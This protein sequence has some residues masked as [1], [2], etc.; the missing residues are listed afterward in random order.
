MKVSLFSY[1]LVALTL[2]A[3]A[4]TGSNAQGCMGGDSGAGVKVQG[5]IQ[6]QFNYFMN[7]TDADG[8]SLDVNN[9]T[10]NR[11]RIGV[12]G[13]I[14]YDIEY[15]FFIETSS[16]KTPGATP[17]MLDAYVSYTRFSKWAKLSLG[18][19]KSPF[20]LEQNTSCSGL[21]T[22]NRS[23]VVNQLAGPQRDLGVMISGGHDTMYVRYSVGL[24]NGTGINIV[25]NNNNK[26]IVGRVVIIPHEMFKV[27]GSFRASKI[28]PTDDT[29]KL[30]DMTV[31]GGEFQ[32]TWKDLI[33]QA[34]YIQG[35]NKLYSASKIPIYGG[36]GGIVGYNTLTE[37]TYTK[38]GMMFMAAYKT[39]W[40][41]EPVFK[42]DTWDPDH[43]V[44]TDMI[45]N[46]TAGIN[47]Y[48]NDYSRVQINYVN[49]SEDT[50]VDN[51]MI[52]VQFQAKF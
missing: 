12:L 19:F 47:Y 27:G 33:V 42:F 49:V 20:S 30:N 2:W 44:S 46:I 41:I 6:P 15:Y 14:P 32:F 40:N 17:H 8:K 23:D 36:C 43:S 52:M 10:F 37:G 48:V 1:V 51:D 3:M 34:E 38:S 39:K 24:M 21:Y 16:F 5:F 22:V 50:P 26:D 45:T 31:F 25:D 13:E 9:F 29:Q 7:G 18:Q 11:A 28:N 4:P 35:Q